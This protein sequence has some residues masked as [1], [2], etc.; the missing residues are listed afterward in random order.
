MPQHTPTP[1]R[2]NL[3]SD[4]Y[5]KNSLKSGVV[6]VCGGRGS[7]GGVLSSPLEQPVP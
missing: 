3:A 2:L 6:C 1:Y 7:G 5:E 4:D